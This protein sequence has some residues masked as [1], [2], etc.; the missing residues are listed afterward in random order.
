MGELIA[1]FKEAVSFCKPVLGFLNKKTEDEKIEFQN[2]KREKYFSYPGL[3]DLN[4]P[5]QIK[6]PCS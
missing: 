1:I 3:E 6:I 4:D 2:D 5:P